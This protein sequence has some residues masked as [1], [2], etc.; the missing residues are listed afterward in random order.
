MQRLWLIVA[1]AISACHR[2]DDTVPTTESPPKAPMSV[3]RPITAL[4][5]AGAEKPAKPVE[6]KALTITPGHVDRT[7]AVLGKNRAFTAHLLRGHDFWRERLAKAHGIDSE[8]AH[9]LT[10]GDVD[11]DLLDDL[12]LCMPGGLPNRLFLREPNGS[13]ADMSEAS[14]ADW[15]DASP[16]ALFLD[17]DDNGVTDL[18]VVAADQLL[19]MENEG[20]GH[21]TVRQ[22]LALTEPTT[23]LQASDHDGDG[24]LDLWAIGENRRWIRQDREWSFVDEGPV[25]ASDSATLLEPQ[26]LETAAEFPLPDDARALATMDWD[27]DGD[28]D[29]WI[30]RRGAPRVQLLLNNAPT[31][32][33]VSVHLLGN[34]RTTSR[35]AIGATVTI[36]GHTQRRHAGHVV[37]SQSSSWL[38]FQGLPPDEAATATVVWPGG[39][40]QTF[41]D[42]ALN[43]FYQLRQGRAD[44][45]PWKPSPPADLRDPKAEDAPHASTVRIILPQGLPFPHP[46]H[47]TLALTGK[48][49]LLKLWA[50]DWEPSVDDLRTWLA[51]TFPENDLEIIL[52]EVT[53]SNAEADT[54]LANLSG[55]FRTLTLSLESLHLIDLFQQAS[56]DYKETL[57]VPSAFL[58]DAQGYVKALYKGPVD[59]DLVRGDLPL[60]IADGATRRQAGVPFPGRWWSPVPVPDPQRLCALLMDRGAVDQA[61]AYLQQV[62]TM[63]R[64]WRP[65]LLSEEMAAQRDIAMATL[66]RERGQADAAIEIYRQ[67]LDQRPNDL[68]L[69][70]AFTDYLETLGR[71]EAA[72]SQWETILA[73]APKHLPTL[74]KL[75]QH[76]WSQGNAEAA[77]SLLD[78]LLALEPENADY[79]CDR[80]RALQRLGRASEAVRTYARALKYAANHPG[81]SNGF[82]WI[83][84]AH[85]QKSMRD[86]DLANRLATVACRKTEHQN[87]EYLLTLSITQ[88]ATG[89]FEKATETVDQALALAPKGQLLDQ[90]QS[91]RD[92]F[93]EKNVFRDASLK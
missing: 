26:P 8:A 62:N 85:P 71:T 39:E 57:P 78:Q 92:L 64:Q 82:A 75:R 24:D 84:S 93:V 13:F 15:L 20:R 51:E 35:E 68:T 30:A 67:A 40:E 1:I 48:P 50:A 69:R 54:M 77:L 31:T 19:L 58:L 46:V 22:A 2:G 59:P 33:F 34:G 89:A 91:C 41:A 53:P 36:H 18:A 73:Q 42:L 9:G 17:F 74:Q 29:T 70:L 49:T 25:S 80:G 56:L 5:D 16:C 61:A 88:A 11:G 6:D 81:A 79:H 83:R 60:L 47:E 43:S 32:N 23:T 66:L 87:P 12:Y 65:H 76:H 38:T 37:R 14:G 44:A 28:A 3:M 10:L 4:M 63:D 86:E 7:G 21:F 90:L 27:F 52:A 55:P 72:V 45:V